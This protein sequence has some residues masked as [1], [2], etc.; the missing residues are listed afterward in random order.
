MELEAT[1]RVGSYIQ[2]PAQPGLDPSNFGC[3]DGSALRQ[4]NP[5][6]FGAE[7]PDQ[8]VSGYLAVHVSRVKVAHL[9]LISLI[10]AM[11]M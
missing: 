5:G 1:P 4:E 10:R 11:S 7:M 9:I 6:A 2:E 8:L 3:R